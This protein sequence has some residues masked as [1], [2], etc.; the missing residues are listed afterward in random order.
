MNFFAI[1]NFN[2]IHLS[3]TTSV[4][5]PISQLSPHSKK[6]LLENPLEKID[7]GSV[8]QTKKRKRNDQEIPRFRFWEEEEDKKLL[9]EVKKY[10]NKKPEW[11]TIGANVFGNTNEQSELIQITKRCKSRWHNILKYDVLYFTE[12]VNNFILL[13]I[14][15]LKGYGNWSY[16]AFKLTENKEL[17]CEKFKKIS[18]LNDKIKSLWYRVLKKTISNS[19]EWVDFPEQPSPFEF[20]EQKYFFT[21]E[22]NAKIVNDRNK[23]YSWRYI[24]EN[25]KRNFP[26]GYK[27]DIES[28]KK[29]YNS[30]LCKRIPL[31]ISTRNVEVQTN[32]PNRLENTDYDELNVLMT[33]LEE[34]SRLQ[35]QF[36]DSSSEKYR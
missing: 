35:F 34:E 14:K 29:I 2:N 36:N 33:E 16:I 11:K 23:G 30:I 13:Q 32:P 25:L 7:M 28:I 15:E 17:N 24:A 1:S 18:A 8:N 4:D 10:K 20:D 26:K 12:S 22:E 31:P 5:S 9:N 21:E 3:S 6:G 19:P 27:H